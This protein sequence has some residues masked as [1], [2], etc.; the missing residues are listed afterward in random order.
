MNARRSIPLALL[1]TATAVLATA[2]AATATP[3]AAG[4]A[5]APAAAPS[6]GKSKAAGGNG[7]SDSYAYKHPCDPS[8]VS[9]EVRYQHNVG[10]SRRIIVVSNHGS[11]ACGLSYYPTVAISDS[12]TVGGNSHPTSF[13]TPKVPGGLGGAPYVPVYAGHSVYA[14]LDLNPSHSAAGAVTTYDEIDVKASDSMPDAATTNHA[15]RAQPANSGNPSVKGPLLSLYYANLADA[16][17]Q[18]GNPSNY[19]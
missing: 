1:A 17:S 2:C 10:D 15:V 5:S 14:V 9:V 3:G 16:V 8:Q 18:V 7:S 19:K 6:A 11:T 13:A 4:S 12:R